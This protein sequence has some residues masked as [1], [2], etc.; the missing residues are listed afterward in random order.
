MALK[1]FESRI[2]EQ[3]GKVERSVEKTPSSPRGDK[4]Y[5]RTQSRFGGAK[6]N[7][8]EQSRETLEDYLGPN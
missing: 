7:H 6:L 2:S 5:Q 8:R 4:K 3:L 1:F